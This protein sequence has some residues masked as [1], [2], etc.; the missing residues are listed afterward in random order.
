[1]QGKKNISATSVWSEAKLQIIT[2]KAASYVRRLLLSWKLTGII[3]HKGMMTTVKITKDKVMH[4]NDYKQQFLKAL[5]ESHYYHGG[6]IE[7]VS[8]LQVIWLL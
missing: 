5:A 6:S 1:M 3:F 8:G 4:K 2:I 7:K